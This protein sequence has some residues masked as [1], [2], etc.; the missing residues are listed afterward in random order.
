MTEDNNDLSS[1]TAVDKSESLIRLQELAVS[2]ALD[3]I[4]DTS[5]NDDTFRAKTIKA[6]HPGGCNGG[7]CDEK[8]EAK[9]DG[10]EASI[11]IDPFQ[12]RTAATALD[13]IIET[14]TGDI[15]GPG[16]VSISEEKRKAA[17]PDGASEEKGHVKEESDKGGVSLPLTKENSKPGAF[18]IPGIDSADATSEDLAGLKDDFEQEGDDK[19]DDKAG[20]GAQQVEREDSQ[21]SLTPPLSRQ[22]NRMIN[23]RP[24]AFSIPGSLQP[25]IQRISAAPQQE[26]KE[27]EAAM[28]AAIPISAEIVEQEELARKEIDATRAKLNEKLHELETMQERMNEMEEMKKELADLRGA[29]ETSVTAEAITVVPDTLFD[30]HKEIE[31]MKQRQSSLVDF[32]DREIDALQM[33]LGAEPG[34]EL[35][36]TVSKEHKSEPPGDA[37]ETRENPERMAPD[38]EVIQQ[39]EPS[40]CCLIL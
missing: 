1:E 27:E 23:D 18:H 38:L 9:E 12:Q 21:V 29:V 24:G 28:V 3:E 32:S 36:K 31:K 15:V 33:L 34:E 6:A 14:S 26:E 39:V 25:E 4:V 13:E 2:I 5:N 10:D 30:R 37:A 40:S 22:D 8:Q 17:Y 19:T 35:P 20:G 11:L 16:N 7:H